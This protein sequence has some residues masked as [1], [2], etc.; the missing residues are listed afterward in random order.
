MMNNRKKRYIKY[1]F[2]RK[3]LIFKCKLSPWMAISTHSSDEVYEYNRNHLTLFLFTYLCDSVSQ[4]II[5]FFGMMIEDKE[6][7][8]TTPKASKFN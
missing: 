7:V 6:N 8:M 2:L 1:H 4:I 3:V 5:I